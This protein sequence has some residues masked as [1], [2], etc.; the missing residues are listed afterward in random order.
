MKERDKMFFTMVK[1]YI[2]VEQIATR[3][4]ELGV[5]LTQQYA[6]KNDLVVVC[7]LKG[8]SLFTM[9]LIR[10]INLP[11][12]LDFIT[13]ASYRGTTERG[14]LELIHELKADIVGRPVLLVEDIIDSGATVAMLYDLL[15]KKNPS[16]L[17][18][19]ALLDKPSKRI[20]PVSVDYK[21][22]TIDDLF[23]VGYGLDYEQKYRNLP[24]IG[25]LSAE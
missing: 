19:C 4:A 3:I 23:V 5:Q 11:L 2:T 1:P 18:V 20:V 9:D 8:A 13:V 14:E 17:H 16:S 25:V 7:V 10:T 22:F 15:K 24:Y 12:E 21:A 6:Q